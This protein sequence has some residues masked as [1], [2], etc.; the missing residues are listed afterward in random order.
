M[1]SSLLPFQLQQEAENTEKEARRKKDEKLDKKLENTMDAQKA[2]GR[3]ESGRTPKSLQLPMPQEPAQA[4]A[5]LTLSARQYQHPSTNYQHRHQ[6]QGVY[7]WSTMCPAVRLSTRLFGV[8][9]TSL[10][11][12]KTPQAFLTRISAQERPRASSKMGDG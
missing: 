11:S 8:N 1:V 10:R 7:P 6:H 5:P 12:P 4:P 9:G 3:T 2:D